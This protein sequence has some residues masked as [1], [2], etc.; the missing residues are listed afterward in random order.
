MKE[1]GKERGERVKRT[2]KAITIIACEQ[3]FGL[4]NKN[5]KANLP[6]K[7]TLSSK[8]AN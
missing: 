1:R 2:A 7:T 5:A 4:A 8:L 6:Q 3:L